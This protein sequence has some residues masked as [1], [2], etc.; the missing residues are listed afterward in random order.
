VQTSALGALVCLILASPALASLL[1][2]HYR[3]PLPRDFMLVAPLLGALALVPW[4]NERARGERLAGLLGVPRA[5]APLI[6]ATAIIAVLGCW[7]LQRIDRYRTK[8]PFARQLGALVRNTS[9]DALVFYQ[10]PQENVLFYADLPVPVRVSVKPDGMTTLLGQTTT[11]KIVVVEQVNVEKA[12]VAL[13][14]DVRRQPTLTE[15]VQPWE[16]RHARTKQLAWS[17][18]ATGR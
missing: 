15:V 17:I 14:A 9:P 4:M 10:P 12:L 16:E 2:P 3:L 1:A 18:P 11:S 8:A 7:S 5:A 6:G 13:P